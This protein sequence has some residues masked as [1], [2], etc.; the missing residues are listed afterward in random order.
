M[1][2]HRYLALV[3]VLAAILGFMPAL[4]AQAAPQTMLILNSQTGDYIG[5][6]QSFEY[7][8][9]DGSFSVTSLF[10]GGIQVSFSSPSHWWYLEFAP[11]AGKPLK[12]AIYEG[13][14]RS[15]FKSPETPGLD[16]YGDGRGCNTLTGRFLI[17]ELEIGAGNTVTRFAADFEQHCEGGPA[18]LFGSIRYQSDVSI[19]PRVSFGDAIV[20]K[21]NAGRSQVT[22]LATLSM[23]S[24]KAARAYYSTADGSARAGNDYQAAGGQVTFA[25]GETEKAIAVTVYG[26][27]H[28]KGDLDF[29]V[30]ARRDNT[31]MGD[32]AARLRLLDPNVPMT[33]LLM[34]SQKGDY[35][36]AGQ[37]WFFTD[38]TAGFRASHSE[39]K[40]VTIN[41]DAPNWMNVNMAA[42]SG[43]G[44]VLMTY[45]NAGRYPF[46]PAGK[47]GLDVS[48]DGRGC[49]TLTGQFTVN[50]ADFGPAQSVNAFSADFEQHCE[51]GDPALF[52]AVRIN[53]LLH[54]ASISDARI[55]GSNAVFT[56]TLNPPGT[57]IERVRFRTVRDTAVDNTDF[58]AVDQKLTFVPGVTSI[59]V[60]VPLRG[61]AR[62]GTRFFGAL[63]S[64]RTPVWI[65]RA[66][67]LIP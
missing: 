63:T 17:S 23:P 58:I 25:P 59:D 8:T 65:D 7:D 2:R 28:A 1:L 34:N 67:A 64:Q 50:E 44:L 48:G 38:E 43:A 41:V 22:V 11:P 10:G 47:P 14:T 52:G 21:A 19:E 13:A 29:F 49:N 20:K 32:S 54:Q 40:V 42:P 16:V 36:G 31:E 6:G 24:S 3:F 46:Q 15:A 26:N 5:G 55:V 57:T 9:A 45:L 61:T 4:P 39:S 62:R 53:S 18:A 27:R 37:T 12:A 66:S 35:I 51:G 33:A 30:R 60:K 56:V